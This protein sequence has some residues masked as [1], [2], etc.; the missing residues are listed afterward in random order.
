MAMLK[1]SPAGLRATAFH[2]AGH[3]VVG[4][5]LGM[6]FEYISIESDENDGFYGITWWDEVR[7][8]DEEE[9]ACASAEVF[10]IAIRR[11]FAGEMAEGQ[12]GC[13]IDEIGGSRDHM[14]VR[15]LTV[16]LPGTP[17][18]RTA[19]LATLKRE[20]RDLLVRRWEAVEVLAAAL[21]ERGRMSGA[22]VQAALSTI[23]GKALV[24]P[25]RLS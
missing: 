3:A 13:P 5:V 14:H 17:E 7:F 16:G 8:F 15:M 20:T 21:L 19:R 6:R 22:D 4:L 2:E 11:A 25:E 18:E 24:F 12:A 23:L 9:K 1:R 10:E